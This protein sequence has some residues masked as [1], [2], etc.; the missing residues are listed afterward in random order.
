M[1]V[2]RPPPNRRLPARLMH[3]PVLN[4]SSR[5]MRARIDLIHL[6]KLGGLGVH[7]TVPRVE[8]L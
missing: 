2:K 1:Q 7:Y 8:R 6:G 5:L 3:E 4:A